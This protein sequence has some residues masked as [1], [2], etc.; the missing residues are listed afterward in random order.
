MTTNAFSSPADGII[1]LLGGIQNQLTEAFA[2]IEW[3]EDEIAQAIERHPQATDSLYHAF[4]L[5]HPR[6]IG[7]GM[8]TEPVY[9][10]HARELLE[11]VAAGRRHPSG[12][13]R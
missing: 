2:T 5:L 1:G 9:R 12:D 4:S 10:S 13:R 6:E 7:A 3:A 11:R 8:H